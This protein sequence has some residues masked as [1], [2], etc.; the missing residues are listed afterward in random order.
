MVCS[1]YRM[2]PVAINGRNIVFN[3][4]ILVLSVCLSVTVYNPEYFADYFISSNVFN[5]QNKYN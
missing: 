4:D 5:M 3:V 2:S 1:L